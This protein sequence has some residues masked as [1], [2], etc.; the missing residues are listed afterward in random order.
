ML[1][2][3]PHIEKIGDLLAVTTEIDFDAVAQALQEQDAATPEEKS[4]LLQLERVCA[5]G[6]QLKAASTGT[7]HSMVAIF[8]A[9]QLTLRA[10][11][12]G[13]S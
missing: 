12:E 13:H 1:E 8:M 9:Y 7:L 3:I 6:K 11:A 4:L 10:D 5:I 2:D